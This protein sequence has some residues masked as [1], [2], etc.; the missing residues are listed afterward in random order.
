MKNSRLS[1]R[2]KLNFLKN[3]SGFSKFRRS[4]SG[5]LLEIAVE[6]GCVRKIHSLG[7]PFYRVVA[8]VEHGLGFNYD[9]FFYVLSR[10]LAARCLNLAGEIFGTYA[11]L[12]GVEAHFSL[13]CAVLLQVVHEL[14]VQFFR[15]SG[16]L[17]K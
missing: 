5:F 15:P 16:R 17:G 7:N 10:R 14:E 9:P 3:I 13:R 12:F 2:G 8:G 6:E 11:P 1:L 4:H